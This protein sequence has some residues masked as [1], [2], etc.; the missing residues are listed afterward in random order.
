VVSS[1]S[2]A[3]FP[4]AWCCYLILCADKSYYCGITSNLR[5]RLRNHASGKGARFTKHA[6]PLALVWFEVHASK[7]SAAAREK[8]IKSWGNE[9]KRA[10][11]A[12]EF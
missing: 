1:N 6:R 2:K 11:A 5:L 7:H 4:T 10:L 3:D 9:K 12:G 8:Q